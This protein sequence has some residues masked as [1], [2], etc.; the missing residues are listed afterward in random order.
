MTIQIAEHTLFAE[1][2][3]IGGPV[4]K[5]NGSAPLHNATQAPD[6][7][8]SAQ[9]RLDNRP[10][11]M[12][13]RT[14]AVLAIGER[15]Q[16]EIAQL[17]CFSIRDNRLV[18]NK[19]DAKIPLMRLLQLSKGEVDSAIIPCSAINGHVLLAATALCQDMIML[20]IQIAVPG[21]RAKLVDLTE[22]FGLTPSE[23]HIVELLLGGNCP[24]K[25]SAELNI[26]VHTVRAHLRRCYD[27]LGVSS[28]EELWQ[29]LAPYH[30][31]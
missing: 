6:E 13:D 12:L 11:M 1:G 31:Y 16:T 23:A 21:Q 22:A 29:T 7:I 10:H 26:S 14:G 9:E 4:P 18:P 19:A 30:I 28:R 2:H 25:I 27:K 8:L 24:S 5:P 17:C 15:A 20:S 3:S